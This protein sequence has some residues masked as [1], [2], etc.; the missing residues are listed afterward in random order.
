MTQ[1]ATNFAAVVTVVNYKD[2]FV[3]G[4]V[5]TAAHALPVLEL[6]HKLVLLQRDPIGIAQSSVASLLWGL[7]FLV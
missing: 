6:E 2:A 3:T 1:K 4:F 7:L 5:S